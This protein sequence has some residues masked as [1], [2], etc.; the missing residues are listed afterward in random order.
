MPNA[1]KDGYSLDR[2]YNNYGYEPMNLRWV[3]KTVQVRNTRQIKS[4]NKSGYRGVHFSN[5]D[6][7]WKSSISISSKS[8]HLGYF[9][10]A[11]E[12]AIAYDKY[13]LENNLEHTINNV[14]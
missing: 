3:S 14:H 5:A 9:N 2:V 7:K 13:V 8:I 1:L 6:K 10:T 12:A 4:T 11:K